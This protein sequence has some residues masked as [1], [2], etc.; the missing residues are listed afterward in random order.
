[1]GGSFFAQARDWTLHGVLPAA[2]LLDWLI[3]RGK[4]VLPWRS[5]LY[6]LIFP[7][8]YCFYSLVRGPISG[9]YP[10]YFLDPGHQ[11]SYAVVALGCAVILV[12]MLAL[13]SFLILIDRARRRWSSKI[14]RMQE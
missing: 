9:W 12:L 10:Y 14:E 5:M 8:L 7:L 3:D 13:G 2:F 11:G 4:T 1:M 6:W